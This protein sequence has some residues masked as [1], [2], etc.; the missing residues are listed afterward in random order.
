[1]EEGR[2]DPG[3]D[4]E[5]DG[6]DLRNLR[7]IGG[8]EPNR[9]QFNGVRALMLAVL[10]DAIRCYLEGRRMEEMEAEIWTLSRERSSPFAFEVVCET[11]G[12]DAAAVRGALRRMKNASE[13]RPK[14]TR[15]L[16]GNA[17]V[18]SQVCLRPRRRRSRE[19][20]DAKRV[21]SA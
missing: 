7:G 4:F 6:L 11:L 2:M 10:E 5:S 19:R 9:G 14:F 13:S 3:T 1:M 21:V 20:P 15:R 8:G 16:R 18:P 12:L 17:R